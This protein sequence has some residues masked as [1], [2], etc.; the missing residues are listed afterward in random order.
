MRILKN[1]GIPVLFLVGYIVFAVIYGCFINDSVLAT[2][3]LDMTAAIVGL[4]YYRHHKFQ[5]T[6]EVYI[7]KGLL[8]SV[9]ILFV[10]IWLA[11]QLT[12]TVWYAYLGDSGIDRR[13]DNISQSSSLL[14]FVLTVIMAPICEEV[15]MRGIMFRHFRDIMPVPVA[16]VLSSFVFAVMHGAVVYIFVGVLFGLF[17]TLVYQMTGSLKAAIATHFVYNLITFFSGYIYLPDFFF[18]VPF[19]IYLDITAVAGLVTIYV[20]YK[21]GQKHNTGS[22]ITTV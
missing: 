2:I 4:F 15:L 20:F 1:I 17:V 16:A 10:F 14:Y 5:K 3:F 12:A 13:N 6:G 18:S 22:D 8:I 7:T 9:A 11:S 19:V 21:K